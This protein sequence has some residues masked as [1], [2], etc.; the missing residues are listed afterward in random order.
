MPAAR[1]WR[2]AVQRTNQNNFFSVAEMSFR[3]AEGADLSV[4][5]VAIASSFYDS[6]F[7]PS[8]AFDKDLSVSSRWATGLGNLPCWIGY[9]HPVAVTPAALWVACDNNAGNGT[10]TMPVSDADVSIEYS[11]DG[12]RWGRLLW[13]IQS[14]GWINGGTIEISISH[15]S[16]AAVPLGRSVP[17]FAHP[18]GGLQVRNGAALTVVDVAYGGSGRLWGTTKVK[19]PASSLPAKARVVLLHQRSKMLVREVWSRPATGEF[20]FENIDTTQQFL[21]LAEDAA[22]NFRPVAASRL[23]PEVAP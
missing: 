1:Y 12:E 3:D 23:V 20:V 22:G 7:A 18:P 19:G 4:G 10:G 17:M 21:V 15:D 11:V 8:M 2:L 16:P 6:S 9:V 5:G 13:S 14:G